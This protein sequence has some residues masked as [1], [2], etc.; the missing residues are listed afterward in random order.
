[1]P[2]SY[3]SSLRLNLQF[4][5]EGINTWG[6]TLNTGV[7]A[8]VD[9]ALAGWLNKTI[10]G[11]YTLTTANGSTDEARAAMLKF[12]AAALAANATITIPSVS[13]SYFVFN[14]T[15]KVLTFTTGAGSTV[16]VDAGDKTVIYC[17]GS[18]VHTITFGT[19]DLK[20]YITAQ[21]ASAGAVPGT[22]GHLGKFL[23]VTVDGSAPTW[24]Q[25][26]TSDL[27]AFSASNAQIW[28]GSSSL[29]AYTPA[30]V[31]SSSAPQA[32][33]YG[34]TVTPDLTLGRN[35]TLT[36]TGNVALANPS[37]G[38]MSAAIGQYIVITITQDGTGSRLWTPG[39]Y[40][41]FPGGT[42]ALSTAAGAV[43]VFVGYV[44]S[45]TIIRGNL[46]KAFA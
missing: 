42:P 6:D 44:E 18:A 45:A 37:A 26:A 43:D 39:A 31:T 27:V 19:Y 5:G 35:W 4:P 3:S 13:K 1:M 14:N 23:K 30:N 46:L 33:T 24:Q 36:L 9:Y 16:S 40:Y 34:A 29:V 10:T 15:N 32:L 20:T 17:D 7:F 28:A 25:L 12:T 2:S 8:L 38:S 11:D 22:V 21:T 41:K